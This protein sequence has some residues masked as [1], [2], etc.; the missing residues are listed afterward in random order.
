MVGILQYNGVDHRADLLV[1]AGLALTAAGQAVPPGP[2]RLMAPDIPLLGRASCPTRCTRTPQADHGASSA[3]RLR[4][5]LHSVR[6]RRVARV[7]LRSSPY[8]PIGAIANDAHR[9]TV[10]VADQIWRSRKS[11]TDP[12]EA[13]HMES[14]YRA[15]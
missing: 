14:D 9:A 10:L 13:S 11:R 8:D 1:A 12:D 6:H 15:P 7:P 2:G 3:N 4:L 5:H